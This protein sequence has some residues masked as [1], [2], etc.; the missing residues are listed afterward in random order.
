MEDKVRIFNIQ[1]FSIHDGPGIRT[2]V[3]FKGCP[4][5]CPWCSNPESQSSQVQLT[6][7]AD[8]CIN[9]RRCEQ[10]GLHF[11]DKKDKPHLND[12]GYYL[13]L[14]KCS[15]KEAKRYSKI[16]P[17]GAIEYEGKD[18][19]Y[20]KIMKAILQDKSFYDES[21]GGM[22][23]SG[24]E[25][26]VQAEKAAE[27]FRRCREEGI[28]TAAETTCFAPTD[29]FL[30]F[31]EYLDLLL[32]DIK[33]WDSTKHQQIVGVDLGQIHQNIKLATKQKGLEII[34]RIPV[35]PG[36]N[37]SI[38]DAEQFVILLNELGIKK[39]NLLPFHNMGENK[40]KLLNMPYLYEGAKNLDTNSAEFKSYEDVFRKAG[41]L[42]AN[43]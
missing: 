13:E 3:F 8:K 5:H 27:L 23:I 30:I 18:R 15:E 29:K 19:S 12:K 34:G 21:G 4:L 28:H 6:W 26:L 42:M 7:D 36:F 38:H 2:T 9:C 32:C 37:F 24:G 31:I 43:P 33:H 10:E 17:T 35:I 25:A 39:V 41:L 22:T 40:Y 1:K 14:I 20:D 16:C 11:S